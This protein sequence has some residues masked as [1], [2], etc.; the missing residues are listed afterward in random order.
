[1]NLDFGLQSSSSSHSNQQ[2]QGE[3]QRGF[4][5]GVA[6]EARDGQ[7]RLRDQVRGVC[8]T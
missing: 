3:R 6:G 5:S 7:W 2:G 1:M 4:D 8:Y